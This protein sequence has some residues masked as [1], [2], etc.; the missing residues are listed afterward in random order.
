MHPQ[1][2]PPRETVKI[3]GRKL[4][5]RASRA[6]PAQRALL[7]HDLETG[8][9]ELIQPTRRQAL[10]LTGASG[11]YLN[12]VSCLSNDDQARLRN[13][14]VTLSR[15]HRNVAERTIESFVKRVGVAR[16]FNVIDRLTQPAVAAE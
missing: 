1:I 4:A 11:G 15:L 5:A 12:A 14:Y 13:G 3:T 8:R 9:I 10:A 7:A 2:T 6:R 16:V